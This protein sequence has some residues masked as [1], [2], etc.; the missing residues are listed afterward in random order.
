MIHFKQEPEWK[1]SE[2]LPVFLPAVEYCYYRHDLGPALFELPGGPHGL[3]TRGDD[4]LHKGYSLALL[5]VAFDTASGGAAMLFGRL[6]DDYVG[7]PCGEG[8][9]NNEGDG[10][11]LQVREP[12]H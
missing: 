11:E 12:L 4:V 9:G 10:T 7:Q 2:L 5:Q 6:A 1:S 3:R 8:R